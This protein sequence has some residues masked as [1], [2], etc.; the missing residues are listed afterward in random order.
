[1]LPSPPPTNPSLIDS[2]NVS[3]RIRIAEPSSN[4]SDLEPGVSSNRGLVSNET[5]SRRIEVG[6]KKNLNA[7]IDLL[8]D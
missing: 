8:K 2:N 7:T 4:Y 6:T 3:S 5:N 1:M